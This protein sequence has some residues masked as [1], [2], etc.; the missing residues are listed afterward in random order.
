MDMLTQLTGY[1]LIAALCAIAAPLSVVFIA[2]VSRA[3]RLDDDDP[4]SIVIPSAQEPDVPAHY[5]DM[6]DVGEVLRRYAED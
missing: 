2:A 6:V 5:G 3:N 4:P 1:Q